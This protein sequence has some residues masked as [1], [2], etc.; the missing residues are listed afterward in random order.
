MIFLTLMFCSGVPV[1]EAGTTIDGRFVVQRRVGGG[2]LGE[3]FEAS[4]IQASRK[5][6]IKVQR[7]R[8]FESASEFRSQG[9]GL[10]DDLRHAQK[11]NGI[12]GIPAVYGCGLHEGR[13]YLI[14]QFVNGVALSRLA[15]RIRPVYAQFAASVLAQLCAILGQVHDRGI[16]HRDIK[17]DN[18]MV[19]WDGDVW[20]VDLGSA[21]ALNE[22]TFD[23]GGTHGYAPP[24]QYTSKPHT[25]RSDIY[26]LGA[27]LFDIC[28]MRV[29][30]QGHEGPRDRRTPQFPAG[31][32]DSMNCALRTLG[33]QM[34]AFEPDRRPANVS[35]VLAALEPMLPQ[36][37]DARDPK[38][39]DPD[40]AEWYRHGLHLN[41]RAP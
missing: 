9:E 38:A 30:Y 14:M 1:I 26:A 13:R 29:P 4:D 34:V 6:A 10:L 15:D 12:H 39:P 3:V 25:A 5:V 2:S 36:P 16:V 8:T 11:L 24:E 19:G 27:T 33:L 17:P 28:V 41:H 18:V 37:G 20:L 23:E 31:A 40:P 7:S 32:L 35:A 22:G 21:I